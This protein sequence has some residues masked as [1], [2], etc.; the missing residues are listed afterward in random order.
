M[1]N[2]LTIADLDK[3]VYVCESRYNP[4]TK[5]VKKI[6]WWNLPEN[7]RVK[8]IPRETHLEPVREV[9]SSGNATLPDHR[10]VMHEHEA[11]EPIEKAKETIP[12]DSVIN[13]KLN[14]NLREKRQ[15]Y[16]QVVLGNNGFWKIGDYVYLKENNQ[17]LILHIEQIWKENE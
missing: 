6:K 13:E 17:Q 11:P 14:E 2:A 3:D 15:F 16:E 1:E 8:L 5:V 4:K 9:L 12:Y 10:P 7:K